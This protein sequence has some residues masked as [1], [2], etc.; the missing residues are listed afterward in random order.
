M[1]S[2]IKEKAWDKDF[3]KILQNDWFSQILPMSFESFPIPVCKNI[4]SKKSTEGANKSKER[5][6]E[7]GGLG[8]REYT[9]L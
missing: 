4:C 7:M 8:S 2:F 9:K 1:N 3:I 5:V 6:V